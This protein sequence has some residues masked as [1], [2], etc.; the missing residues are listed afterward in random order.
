MNSIKMIAGLDIGN[1]YVKGTVQAT[2]KDA[3]TVDFMSG[4]AIETSSSGIKAKGS[5]IAEEVANIYNVMEA[6]FDTP[7]V[8]SRTMR[9]FGQRAARS[10]KAMEEFDVASSSSKAMQD[11]SAML[12]LGSLAGADLQSYYALP[13]RAAR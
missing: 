8:K 4:V 13:E 12:V 1:G 9:L 3:V 2:G 10:G 11:L 6:S 7:A 5:D